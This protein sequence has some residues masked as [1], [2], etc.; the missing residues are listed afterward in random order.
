MVCLQSPHVSLIFSGSL[1]L[2][3]SC[4]AVTFAG[5]RWWTAWIQ[6]HK[7]ILNVT[8]QLWF[9]I[10][11]DVNR[12]KKAVKCF[13]LLPPKCFN[14]SVIYF[15]ESV[16]HVAINGALQGAHRVRWLTFKKGLVSRWWH[17]SSGMTQNTSP[18]YFIPK[19]TLTTLCRRRMNYWKLK[20]NMAL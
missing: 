12:A 18:E 14:S 7:N 8:I 9:S 19:Q 13:V 15:C 6:V 1:C 16:D 20:W 11:S 10:N 17:G 5:W 2:T 3:I 4:Y